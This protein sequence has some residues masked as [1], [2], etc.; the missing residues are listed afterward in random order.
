MRAYFFTLGAALLLVA[1]SER[2]SRPAKE[3]VAQAKGAAADA[4][5]TAQEAAASVKASAED[6]KQTRGGGHAP[7]RTAPSRTRPKTWPTAS[8]SSARAAW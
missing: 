8:A 6:A 1:C 2:D 7:K 3:V 5:Q 4:K